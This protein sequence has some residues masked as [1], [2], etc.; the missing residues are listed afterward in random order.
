LNYAFLLRII[1]VKIHPI[2]FPQDFSLIFNRPYWFEEQ[3]NLFSWCITKETH[4]FMIFQLRKQKR[5]R[6]SCFEAI[7]SELLWNWRFGMLIHNVDWH[8]WLQIYKPVVLSKDNLCCVAHDN[9]VRVKK[10]LSAFSS[11]RHH[12]LTVRRVAD[13]ARWTQVTCF[14]CCRKLEHIS[15]FISCIWTM[16]HLIG[17][18]EK[19]IFKIF[20]IT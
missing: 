11:T 13:I 15:K 9:W 1:I 5:N 3:H 18:S 14:L 16:R 7:L 12:S 8:F 6:K 10:Y 2:F 19:L 20:N 4:Y 17:E